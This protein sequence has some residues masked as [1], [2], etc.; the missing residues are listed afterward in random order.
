MFESKLFLSLLIIVV[1]AILL[2][3][4]DIAIGADKGM[5]DIG[6][7]KQIIHKTAYMIQG[8]AITFVSLS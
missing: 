7:V 5:S 1:G 6:F 8:G 4:I 2:T 3:F